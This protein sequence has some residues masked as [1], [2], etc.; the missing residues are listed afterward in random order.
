MDALDGDRRELTRLQKKAVEIRKRQLNGTQLGRFTFKINFQNSLFEFILCPI[1][2]EEEELRSVLVGAADLEKKLLRAMD[3]IARLFDKTERLIKRQK[4]IDEQRRLKLLEEAQKNEALQYIVKDLELL[5]KLMKD[6]TDVRKQYVK[7]E[8]LHRN[9][10]KILQKDDKDE[11][12]SD[13]MTLESIRVGTQSATDDILKTRDDIQKVQD[14]FLIGLDEDID[15]VAESEYL[16][17]KIKNTGLDVLKL[18]SEVEKFLLSQ[19]E[20]YMKL[21]EKRALLEAEE[22]KRLEKQRQM[23]EELKKERQR[24][25]NEIKLKD[26]EERK[27]KELELINSENEKKKR[28]QIAE[29]EKKRL[30]DLE[31]E[32]K[33]REQ[34]EKMLQLQRLLDEE[35]AKNLQRQRQEILNILDGDTCEI[36]RMKDQV[37]IL[38]DKQKKIKQIRKK[39]RELY[40]IPEEVE[41]IDDQHIKD[42]LDRT[43]Q[44]FNAL[45]DKENEVIKLKSELNSNLPGGI[46]E[47]LLQIERQLLSQA[48]TLG[49]LQDDTNLIHD[50]H[51]Q[52][53]EDGKKAIEDALNRE[54]ELEEDENKLKQMKDDIGMA[55]YK[56]NQLKKSINLNEELNNAKDYE[57]L[58]NEEIKLQTLENDIFESIKKLDEWKTFNWPEEIET[59]MNKY[60]MIGS[61]SMPSFPD[62]LITDPVI[63]A[64]VQKRREAMQLL[65]ERIEQEAARLKEVDEALE[66]M[67]RR[68]KESELRRLAEQALEWTKDFIPEGSAE[69]GA[70]P[71]F[72]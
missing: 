23:E 68:R 51:F 32:R 62:H 50:K 57:N 11:I 28:L 6:L 46:M 40:T 16:K 3:E 1:D 47:I 26:E 36:E 18:S 71:V 21:L 10:Q 20:R 37:I 5:D 64:L 41:E 44:L 33:K 29:E 13:E 27:R 61:L 30:A 25:E 7:A 67:D 58:K 14:A 63:L 66:E 52:M 54:K 55:K 22:K 53:L 4:A 69:F 38:V 60:G 42:L 49:N 9:I 70:M 43:Q 72:R 2:G 12:D 59:E 45:I 15:I 17:D 31:A 48:D 24:L 35:A 65:R 34:E 19:N 8:G 39:R 56:Q